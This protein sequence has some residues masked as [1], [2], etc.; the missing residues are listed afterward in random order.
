MQQW[1][2]ANPSWKDEDEKQ[3]SD[4]EDLAAQGIMVPNDAFSFN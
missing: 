2:D 1:L 3:L 4:E